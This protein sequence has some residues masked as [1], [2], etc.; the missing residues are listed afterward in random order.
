MTKPRL[1]VWMYG[2]KV[3]QIEQR[4][5]TALRLRHTNEALER[6]PINT[7]LISCSLP[8]AR[9][10]APASTFLRGL[11]PEGRHLQA[12]AAAAN[13][14]TADTYGLLARYGRDVAGAMVITR[15]D[16]EPDDERWGAEPYSD[17]ALEEAIANLNSDNPIVHDDSELSI[18]GLQ[19]KLLLVRSP[20]GGWARPVGGMP[21]THILKIEDPR[22][23]GLI[24]AEVA[25][26]QLAQHLGLTRTNPMMK[27]ID[28]VPCIIVERFDRAKVDG[29]VTRLH[30]E[31]ACQALGINHEAANGRGKYQNAGG[32][33]FAQIA[34]LLDQQAS[35]PP[36]Q[37]ALLAKY[38]LFT[39][40]IGNADAHGK[41][42][43]FL[44][45]D[46]GS[47]ELTP[48]YD[49]VPTVLWP[50]L[51]SAPAMTIAAAPTLSEVQREDLE[52]EIS[53]WPIASKESA[54]AAL[55]N[56]IDAI[57]ATEVSHE[58]LAAHVTA[59]LARIG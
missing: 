6:W 18:P 59:A 37:I 17:T 44:H 15:H 35:D 45:D 1:A 42:I 23:P 29:A 54:L 39:C 53:R 32:P 25:A 48:I 52:A 16:K 24:E 27:S 7:A 10:W 51:R 47:T 28:S 49:A 19:N 33:S 20:D 12:A 46:T 11:L 4:G 57:E 43:G 38:M 5:R 26:T 36:K 40:V 3:A 30:Q 13:V 50:K 41:N 31:D 34:G 9:T 2:T 55:T 58:R 22:Y 8:V 56:T 14:T 21:S